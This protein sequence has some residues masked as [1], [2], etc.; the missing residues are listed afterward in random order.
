MVV[1]FNL[2]P[3]YV[4]EH[5]IEFD[6]FENANFAFGGIV[7]F[8]NGGMGHKTLFDVN[9][10]AD[11]WSWLSMG[12]VPLLYNRAWDVNEVRSNVLS[13]CDSASSLSGWGLRGNGHLA[14]VQASC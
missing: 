8:E 4:Q 14:D 11:F 9:S 13:V 2:R 6:L 5:S 1:R 12:L 3:I 10:V 7:P